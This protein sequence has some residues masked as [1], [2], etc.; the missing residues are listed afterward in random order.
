[1]S[2]QASYLE[3]GT[4]ARDPMDWNPSSPGGRE[5]SGVRHAALT[6]P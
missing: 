4:G 5:V 3:Q 2:V 1:M 6:R